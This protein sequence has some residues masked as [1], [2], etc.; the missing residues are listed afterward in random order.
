MAYNWMVDM[1]EVIL[2]LGILLM[3]ISY[4]QDNF[5]FYGYYFLFG[6]IFILFSLVLYGIRFFDRFD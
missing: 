2:A 3:I 4:F 5:N 1:R 6:G